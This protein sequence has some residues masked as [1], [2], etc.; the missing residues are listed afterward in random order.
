M[1]LQN[2]PTL[3]EPLMRGDNEEIAFTITQ[4][5]SSTPQN[6]SGWTLRFSA[7][8]DLS[9][10]AALITKTSATPG[11]FIIDDAAAGEGRIIIDKT[12]WP[13]AISYETTLIC[14]LECTDAAG[15]RFTRRFKAPIEL[16]VTT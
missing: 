4:P 14:D 10:S 9:D 2:V 16:D 12:D 11:H 7:K 3:D 15:K 13:A 1:P 8:F 6:I 5:N